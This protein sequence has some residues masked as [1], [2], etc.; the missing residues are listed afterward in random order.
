[1]TRLFKKMSADERRFKV[2]RF[3]MEHDLKE[4]KLTFTEG[5]DENMVYDYFYLSP[6]EFQMAPEGSV[7][8]NYVMEVPNV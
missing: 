1:M 2:H 6:D 5:S 7:P 8:T 4:L 3:A